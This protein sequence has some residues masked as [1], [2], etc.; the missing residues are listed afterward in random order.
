MNLPLKPRREKKQ[1]Q[2]NEIQT[3]HTN[4]T[5]QQNKKNLNTPG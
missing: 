1:I 4:Y 3:K 5:I 2:N